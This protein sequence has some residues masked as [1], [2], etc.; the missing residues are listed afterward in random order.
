MKLLA[1]AEVRSELCRRLRPI[2]IQNG[3]VM[4]SD[5]VVTWIGNSVSVSPP[6]S[7]GVHRRSNDEGVLFCFVVL[8]FYIYFVV[9]VVRD[10]IRINICSPLDER[11]ST[12]NDSYYHGIQFN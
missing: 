9:F 5:I 7:G 1:S 6:W 2:P 10:P 12:E 8:Y 3:D 11:I 4:S